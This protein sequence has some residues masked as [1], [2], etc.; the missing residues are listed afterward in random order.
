[1]FL[2]RVVLWWSVDVGL[3]LSA[4]VA[5][6]GVDLIKVYREGVLLLLLLKIKKAITR[7]K[8]I[9]SDK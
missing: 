5:P 9:S 8:R 1:M 2:E 4:K 6:G 7:V 3:F